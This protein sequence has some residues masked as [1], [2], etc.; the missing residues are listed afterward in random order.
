M[1][2]TLKEIKDDAYKLMYAT[3]EDII[4]YENHICEAINYALIELASEYIPIKEVITI[5]QEPSTELG[6]NKYDM[7]K[8]VDESYDGTA[9]MGF[10][11]DCPL[12]LFKDD[13]VASVKDYLITLDRYLYVKKSISGELNVFYKRYPS[14]ITPDTPDNFIMQIDTRACPLI[15]LLVAYRILKDDDSIK[16][17]IYFNEYQNAKSL[18]KST[19]TFKSPFQIDN[20]GSGIYGI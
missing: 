1:N 13:T 17:T 7:K 2:Y 9:F 6:F 12:M 20:G 11:E 5:I 18:L 14:K 10:V 8:L 3:E 15:P 19:E 4:E 16:S